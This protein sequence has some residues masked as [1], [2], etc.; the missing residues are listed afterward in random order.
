MKPERSAPSGTGWTHWESTLVSTISTR[1]TPHRSSSV[2]LWHA[3]C[4]EYEHILQITTA[5]P[6]DVFVCAAETSTMPWWSSSCTRRSKYQ[7]TGTESTNLPT[8]NWAATWRRYNSSTVQVTHD[9]SFCVS[10]SKDSH[11]TV[12]GERHPFMMDMKTPQ[13]IF[14]KFDTVHQ[15]HVAFSRKLKFPFILYAKFAMMLALLIPLWILEIFLHSFTAA[16]DCLWKMFS[17]Q[18]FFVMCRNDVCHY[19]T[20]YACCND[21]LHISVKGFIW[22]G[23]C[24]AVNNRTSNILGISS[25]HISVLNPSLCLC[26]PAGEL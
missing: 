22:S 3:A 1:K 8:L 9:G 25:I 20:Y 15:I 2:L 12:Q 23:L 10:S 21:T 13:N 18:F 4:W 14:I 5:K 16:N 17:F 26:V 6:R 11:L 24:P 7:W 19:D